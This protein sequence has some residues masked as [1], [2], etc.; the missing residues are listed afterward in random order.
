MSP[1]PDAAQK[2][3]S[4]F[5]GRVSERLSDLL[6]PLILKEMR[7]ALRSKHFLIWVLLLTAYGAGAALIFARMKAEDPNSRT[8]GIGAFTACFAMLLFIACGLVPLNAFFGFAQEI[9]DRSL[10]LV[11]ITRLSPFAIMRGKILSPLI[12]TGIVISVLLPFFTFAYL[13]GGIDIVS[14]LVLLAAAAMESTWLTVYALFLAAVA[15]N[16]NARML[17]GGSLAIGTVFGVLV[18]TAGTARALQNQRLQ[19]TLRD[20]FQDPEILWPVVGAGF[21]LISYAALFYTLAAGRISF[22]SANT[23]TAPRAVLAIQWA[24]ISAISLAVFEHTEGLSVVALV[25]GILMA[26]QWY[27]VGIYAATESEFLSQRVLRSRAR[28]SLPRRAAFLLLFPGGRRGLIFS[29]LF[30][31]LSLG[32]AGAMLRYPWHFSSAWAGPKQLAKEQVHALALLLGVAL[33]ALCSV[34]IPLFISRIF[35]RNATNRVVRGFLSL[36]IPAGVLIALI[37]R[38]FEED[39]GDPLS[40]LNPFVSAM[41]LKKYGFS[42]ANTALLWGLGVIWA[43]TFAACLVLKPQIQHTRSNHG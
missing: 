15:P 5:A 4:S 14:I 40:V 32:L 30:S 26:I 37:G 38:L 28:A 33:Y 16:N 18:V 39:G 1:T 7:Q 29:T 35:L 21:F 20:L 11:G 25:Y 17:M 8:L 6:N 19:Q 23:S 34:T 2:R 31:L 43:A 3:P 36:A 22:R 42:P 9:K 10:E 41:A 12:Q 24:G 27:G 13:L